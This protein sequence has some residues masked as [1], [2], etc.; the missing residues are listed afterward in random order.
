MTPAILV[1]SFVC[2]VCGEEF[3]DGQPD[4][5][6]RP[7]MQCPCCGADEVLPLGLAPVGPPPGQLRA[8]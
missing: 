8:A 5:A 2:A 3:A 6:L 1:E 4:V 7:V